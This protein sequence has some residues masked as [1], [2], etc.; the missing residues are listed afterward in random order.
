MSDQL[1]DSQQPWTKAEAAEWLKTHHNKLGYTPGSTYRRDN[2]G[3]AAGVL[4]RLFESS[5]NAYKAADVPPPT[6]RPGSAPRSWGQ[7]FTDLNERLT[8][9]QPT[10]TARCAY[11]G[12]HTT[13]PPIETLEQQTEH[14]KTHG[15]QERPRR[16]NG[17]RRS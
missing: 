15:H 3:P 1:R 7:R 6:R 13:G 2:H 8:E 17:K 5:K 12:W 16:R 4:R 9:N 11:C 10:L 14:I